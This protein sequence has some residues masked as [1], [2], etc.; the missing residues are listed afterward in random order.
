[1]AYRIERR[2]VGRDSRCVT[3]YV[4]GVR[5]GPLCGLDDPDVAFAQIGPVDRDEDVTLVWGVLGTHARQATAAP[6]RA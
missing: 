5:T 4:D 1:M 2:D 6:R 3:F